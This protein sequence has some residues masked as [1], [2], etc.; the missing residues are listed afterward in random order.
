LRIS[1]LTVFTAIYLSLGIIFNNS[2]HVM[3]ARLKNVQSYI[4]FGFLV[5]TAVMFFVME[6]RRR[7]KKISVLTRKKQERL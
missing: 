1:A 3:M 6:K 4:F 5:V 7:K 2:L